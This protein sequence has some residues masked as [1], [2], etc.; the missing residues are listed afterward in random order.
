VTRPGPRVVRALLGGA[1]LA[2][3]AAAL[4]SASGGGSIELGGIRIRSHDATRPALL[5][6]GLMAAARA[7]GAAAVHA[8]LAWWLETVA[9]G[10]HA[11]ALLMAAGAVAVGIFWGT[12]VAGGSDSY[13]YL[14]QAELFTQGRVLDRE[15]LAADREWPGNVWSFSAAGHIPARSPGYYAP[16]CPAGY[17]FLLAAARTI[18]GRTGMFWVTPLMG[19]L[20]VYLAFVLGRRLAGPAA[21]LLTALL[22]ACSP[23]VLYQIVQPM[24]DVP[25]MAMWLAALALATASR[26]APVPRTALAGLAAAYA[27]TI[28]PNLVPLAV[29]AGF[30][31]ALLPPGQTPAQRVKLLIVFGLSSVPGVLTVMAIQNAMY[32]SPFASGYGDLDKLFTAANIPPNL[33]RYPRWLIEVHTPLIAGAAAAPF[34]VNRAARREAIWLLAFAAVTFALYLPYVVFDA[35]WY[36]RFVLPAIPLLIA[37]AAAVVVELL[38]R[39]PLGLRAFAFGALCIA[40]PVTFV[41]NAVEREAFL[42]WQHEARFRAAG[43]YVAAALP[44]N[45][46]LVTNHHSGSARFYA[47]RRTVGWGDIP[48]GRLA[49]AL[50]FLRAR[51]LKPYLLFEE[52]EEP[53]FRQRF[54]GD[55]LGTLEWPPAADIDRYVRLYDPDD[56]DRYARGER[57]ET[58][59]V[60]SAR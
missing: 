24:N 40:L 53:Q 36:L 31:A 15:P 57:V 10:A 23:V 59:L 56:S 13:C 60:T 6:L 30:G 43:E 44:P 1:V 35:W 48:A 26:P 45:A 8:A 28:R 54:A 52:W 4:V 41:T 18:F 46:I 17:P 3:F 14:N 37:L 33:A 55:R 50:D 47:G 58:R 25:A 16:I 34:V 39:T 38:R 12:F 7:A 49:E 51:G 20:A 27:L 9:R 32:G 21:G 2:A 19:G 5:A 22:T 11:L 42:L 29:V